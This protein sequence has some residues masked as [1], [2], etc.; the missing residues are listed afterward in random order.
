MKAASLFLVGLV[1]VAGG[2]GWAFVRAHNAASPAAEVSVRSAQSAQPGQ[3]RTIRFFRDPVQVPSFT[4][5]DLQGRSISAADLKGKVTI[6]NFWATWCGPCRIEIP[7]LI[8]LQNK[9]RSQLQII[10]ISEDEISADEVKRF[11]AASRMNYT[12]AMTT[13]EI[14]RVFPGITALPTTYIVDRDGRIV[15][16]HAGT[17]NAALTE[18]ETRSLAGLPVDAKVEQVDRMQKAQLENGA[19]A[20]S[21]PGIDLAKLTREQRGAA[22]QRLN[23]EGC[24]CGCDL[25]IAKCR[26]D[27]PGCGVSLPLA[28]AMVNQIVKR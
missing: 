26:I 16:R 24:T 9:Y 2:A 14:E 12:V 3:V 13:P 6:I 7:D 25:S 22:L 18:A 5:R 28:K 19:Q 8:A 20:M 17:L 21:I 1:M 11:V 15:M 4:V 10:G 23:S 27:D